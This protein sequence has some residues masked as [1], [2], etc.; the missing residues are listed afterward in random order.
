MLFHGT[1]TA[2][3]HFNNIYPKNTF[4]EHPSTTG[5]SKLR[6]RKNYFQTERSANLLSDDLMVKVKTIMNGKCAVG[7]AI[8]RRIVITIGNRVVKPNN[9]ILLKENGGSLQPTEDWVR[10]VLKSMNWVKRKGTAGKKEPLQQFLLKED[11]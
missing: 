4:L 1:K 2:R 11:V 6:K 9:P 10:G 8:Y 5:N 3:E 7:A